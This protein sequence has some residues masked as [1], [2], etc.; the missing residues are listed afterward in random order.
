MAQKEAFAHTDRQHIAVFDIG[1][2]NKKLLIFDHRLT[3]VDSTYETFEE[4]H[5]DGYIHEPIEE[6]VDWFSTGSGR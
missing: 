5:K 4:F 6:A 1:K 2:T 3:L